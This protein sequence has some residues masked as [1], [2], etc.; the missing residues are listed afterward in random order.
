MD[1]TQTNNTHGPVEAKLKTQG[2]FLSLLEYNFITVTQL[3]L[4]DGLPVVQSTSKKHE[5]EL[6]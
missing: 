1:Q 6:L 3:T 2:L 5:I 4:F